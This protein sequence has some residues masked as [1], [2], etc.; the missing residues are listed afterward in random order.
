MSRTAA[1]HKSKQ[2]AAVTAPPRPDAPAVT[3]PD[4]IPFKPDE[5]DRIAKDIYKKNEE[6]AANNKILMLL[7]RID[8]VVL[9]SITEPTEVVSHLA[10]AIS[11][12]AGFP[13]VVMYLRNHTKV[14]MEPKAVVVKTKNPVAKEDF[15]KS[16]MSN[17]ISMKQPR[18]AVVRSAKHL[19]IVHS[20]KLYEVTQPFLEIEAA[21]EVQD[22]LGLKAFYICPIYARN[23]I[24]GAMVLG[25]EE[26]EAKLSFF[27]KDMLE[28]LTSAVGVAIDD[29]LLYTKTVETSQRLRS[30]NRR[31][32]ELDKAKDEFISMASHQLRTPLTSIK[33]YI[34][35]LSEGDAGQLSPEQLQ[36]LDY[37]FSGT[38]RMVELISDLL[39]VSR[40]QAG[41]FFMEQSLTDLTKMVVEEVQDLQAHAQ[42]KHLEL[43]FTKPKLPIPP[44]NI[45][46]NKTRQVIM[47]FIDNAIY[48]TRKGSIT[49]TLK[50][51]GNRI[52]FRVKDTGI[53]VPEAARAKLFTKFYRAGNAQTLR[54]DGTGLGLFMAKRVVEDQGGTIIFESEEG[55]GS[56]FGFTL[57]V[58]S[59]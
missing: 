49:V 3:Q 51:E 39:N 50:K 26:P 12:G 36:Y 24:L 31:L 6:L 8:K 57:P 2:R 52:E 13:V 47:N 22:E 46:E 34:S 54:P 44:L 56:T 53:G 18:N 32:K 10:E 9:S 14:S 40:M 59:K 16:V 42:P 38:N 23:E 41:R 15:I 11:E 1:H 37:A 27:Q 7:R 29:T 19:F 43:T 58:N 48:Y 28:R 33:G 20:D 21:H 35:M 4:H 55:K 45:D 17:S 30:A 5:L 25:S